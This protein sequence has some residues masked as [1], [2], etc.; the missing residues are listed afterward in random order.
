MELAGE[1]LNIVFQALEQ[2]GWSR[3]TAGVWGHPS[4]PGLTLRTGYVYGEATLKV[5]A[6]YYRGP[7]PAHWLAEQAAKHDEPTLAKR[8]DTLIHQP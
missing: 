8:L 6:L 3:G 7:H 2:E 1:G 4:K 5:G